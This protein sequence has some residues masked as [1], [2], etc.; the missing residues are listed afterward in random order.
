MELSLV[1][2]SQLPSLSRQRAAEVFPV[3]R[4]ALALKPLLALLVILPG[5]Y[6]VERHTLQESDALW[7]LRSLDFLSARSVEDV[8]DPALHATTAR[9]HW[10]PP[11][12]NWL[13]A[14]VMLV[15]GPSHPLT[16]LIVPYLASAA[17]IASLYYFCNWAVGARLAF[18]AVLLLACHPEMLSQFS[19]A[20]GHSLS[21]LLAV[22]TFWSYLQH[23]ETS[24]STVSTR[25][26]F[27]GL[28]LGLCL[29]AGGPLAMLVVAVLMLH[30]LGLRGESA[31]TKRGR[32]NSSRGSWV[33]WPALK[34]LFVM[35]LTGFAVGGWWVM[36]MAS[37]HGGE[38]WNGWLGA[39]PAGGASG[40]E[41]S[42]I[43][44]APFAAIVFDR[45]FS[46]SGAFMGL[47]ILGVY[48]ASLTS[49][50]T[51]PTSKSRPVP[52]LVAWI[53]CGLL[54]WLNLL[55]NPT[56][57]PY[58]FDMWQQFLLIP[59][60]VCAA[61]AIDSIDRRLVHFS[62]GVAV[63]LLSVVAKVAWSLVYREAGLYVDQ[64]TAWAAFLIALG[65][66]SW[67]FYKYR[68]DRDLVQR[69]ILGGL[70]IALVVVNASSGF[71]S[72]R[73]DTAEGS[74]LS[75]FRAELAAVPDVDSGMLVGGDCPPLR[76]RFVLRSIC[77]VGDLTQ[78]D[79]WDGALSRFLSD[80]HADGGTT[81]V[82][83][84]SVRETRP[85]SIPIEGLDI[86]PV[87]SSHFF[88]SRQLRGYLLSFRGPEA[89]QSPNRSRSDR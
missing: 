70:V 13:T 57:P 2:D 5:L 37:R 78:I 89:R 21:I 77:R 82:V 46:L 86:E 79:H 28:S 66:A 54:I 26:L 68:H 55:R 41:A 65:V 72:L 85:T 33:G 80:R 31:P 59:G 25:L 88:A 12:A 40:T 73:R 29:L 18:W 42:P 75:V 23:V 14:L 15:V 35:T 3:L 19:N 48:R 45:L 32:Q 64:S 38:F 53:G 4:R 50:T 9:L 62:V 10:Q 61:L 60:V 71:G 43:L 1:D 44:G 6:A 76:L 83:E 7:G 67:W 36:M 69:I 84:W 22:L 63:I 20:A 11:L 56:A 27:G 17:L 24:R 51:I 52:I 39:F 81:L 8:V 74:P 34:S 47:A 49:D 16:L 30:V 87:T 58:V